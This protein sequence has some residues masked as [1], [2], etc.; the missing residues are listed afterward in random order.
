MNISGSVHVAAL[1]DFAPEGVLDCER[2]L[3]RRELAVGRPIKPDWREEPDPALRRTTVHEVAQVWREIRIA[4]PRDGGAAGSAE[5]QAV[6]ARIGDHD[7]QDVNQFDI[8][9]LREQIAGGCEMRGMELSETCPV[10]R[11][12]LRKERDDVQV[13]HRSRHL[14]IYMRDQ[15]TAAALDEERSIASRQRPENRPGREIVPGQK[16]NVGSASERQNV[17]PGNVVC[18][19]KHWIIAGNRALVLDTNSERFAGQLTKSSAKPAF[20][21]P[22]RSTGKGRKRQPERQRERDQNRDGDKTQRCHG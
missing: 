9:P 19:Q 16:Y 10:A 4:I 15:S 3:P 22:R 7:R 14:T 5:R 13:F 20:Y 11:C 8:V 17:S 6:A 1:H 2:S 18:D 21:D 12:R